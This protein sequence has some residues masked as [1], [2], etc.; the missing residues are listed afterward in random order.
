M[1]WQCARNAAPI[2]RRASSDRAER[3]RA[4]RAERMHKA[5]IG[6]G[7]ALNANSSAYTAVCA[8][9]WCRRR[10][11]ARTRHSVRA[12]TSGD[13]DP[14]SAPASLQ[15]HVTIELCVTRI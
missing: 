6:G 3:E 12:W 4:F 14:L 8:R 7:S 1:R 10:R 15:L 9:N 5:I 11:A 2:V 13:V